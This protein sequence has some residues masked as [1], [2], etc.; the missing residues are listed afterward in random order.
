MSAANSNKIQSHVN[1]HI[2][3]TP[4][5]IIYHP[6]TLV[7][8]A[9]RTSFRIALIQTRSLSKAGTGE[10]DTGTGTG[11][12]PVGRGSDP[13]RT[14]SNSWSESTE[15][16]NLKRRVVATA[17]LSIHRGYHLICICCVCMEGGGEGFMKER[18]SDG[19]IGIWR[20]T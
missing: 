4:H 10:G 18:H 13:P 2:H 6:P 16:N 7:I 5:H 19:V 12:P 9:G 14:T 17:S 15:K 11:T 1:H 20:G 3:T 8:S